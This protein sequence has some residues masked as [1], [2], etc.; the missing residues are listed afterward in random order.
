MG[1]GRRRPALCGRGRRAGVHPRG[2]APGR[3]LPPPVPSPGAEKALERAAGSPHASPPPGDPRGGRGGCP[4]ARL[5]R[6][7]RGS[8][9]PASGPWAEAAAG[10]GGD[11]RGLPL[12]PGCEPAAGREACDPEGFGGGGLPGLRLT[13]ALGGARDALGSSRAAGR[14]YFFFLLQTSGPGPKFC[15]AG[16][17]AVAQP[18]SGAVN[19]GAA[20]PAPR[21]TVGKSIRLGS[22]AALQG[23]K[24]RLLSW[25][26]VPP[27]CP[28]QPPPFYL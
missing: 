15:I 1:E 4:C 2:P 11:T 26:S 23:P 6:G 18:G 12:R 3:A 16:G 10:P 19:L 5:G 9:G 28:A 13:P 27:A 21:G 7:G 17:G 22:L 14:N 25:L 24:L 20:P 8:G